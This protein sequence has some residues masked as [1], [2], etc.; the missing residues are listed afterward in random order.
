MKECIVVIQHNFWNKKMNNKRSK[1][2]GPLC[3]HL[4]KCIN[5]TLQSESYSADITATDNILY[6]ILVES[7]P[8][9]INKKSIL[10]ILVHISCALVLSLFENNFIRKFQTKLLVQK[11]T[12]MWYTMGPFKSFVMNNKAFRKFCNPQKS[13]HTSR[14]R[15]IEAVNHSSNSTIAFTKKFTSSR[16]FFSS[17][18]Y[19]WGWRMVDNLC[20]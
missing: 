2:V 6:I 1:H 8:K 16:N 14:T 9:C 11:V 5:V 7:A 4:N 10:S 12:W 18:C 15:I 17:K 3:M 13:F 20:Y 19:C